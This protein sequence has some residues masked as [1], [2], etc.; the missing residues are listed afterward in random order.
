MHGIYEIAGVVVK[1]NYNYNYT[2]TFLKKYL[3]YGAE[4]F[5][6]EIFITKEDVLFEKSIIKNEDLSVLEQSAILRKLVNV[7]LN[8]Y[9]AVV[10]HGSS[11][12]YKDK[13]FIFTAPSGTGK[14]T[15]T[16]LL[17]ELLKGDLSYINDDKPIIRVIGEDVLVYGSPWNGKHFLGENVKAKLK[18]ICFLAR[19]EENLIKKITPDKALKYLF[20]QTVSY[21]DIKSANSLLGVLSSI[22]DK[23][24]FYVLYCT[25][26]I[27]AAKLSYEVMINED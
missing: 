3:Y 10:F 18:A 23:V 4:P 22:I 17:K 12:K 14:S 26:D 16:A 11:I 1:I 2:E 19:G 6:V 7:F 21:S 27:S 24:D 20:K 25:K 8:D 13:G 9:N 15:H 5:D